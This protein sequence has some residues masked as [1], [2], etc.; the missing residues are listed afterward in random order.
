LKHK[1]P[2][3]QIIEKSHSF[4]QASTGMGNPVRV[5]LP[6]AALYFGM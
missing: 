6:E 2:N 4:A 3:T 5:Q 1:I